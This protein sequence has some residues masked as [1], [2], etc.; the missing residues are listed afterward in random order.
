[1]EIIYKKSKRLEKTYIY[2]ETTT[3]NIYKRSDETTELN[4]LINEHHLIVIF[5]Q[6]QAN[7]DVPFYNHCQRQQ[8]HRQNCAQHSEEEL[9]PH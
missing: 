4:F 5:R 6:E 7:Q 8:T 9:L 3:G 1:M 2:T